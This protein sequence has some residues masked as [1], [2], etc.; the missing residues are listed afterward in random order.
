[1]TRKRVTSIVNVFFQF[2]LVR[3]IGGLFF[4]TQSENPCFG[5]ISINLTELSL[6]LVFDYD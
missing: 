2:F 4:M 3:V 6:N 5:F 1:M